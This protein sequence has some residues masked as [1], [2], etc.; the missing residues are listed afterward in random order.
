MTNKEGKYSFSFI[1]FDAHKPPKFTEVKNK[2]WVIFG[3]DKEYF[4]NYPLYLLDNYD[5]SATHNAIINGKI[6][7]IVGNGLKVN[8]FNSA[9][10]LATAKGLIRSVNANEDADDLNR[11]LA[12]DLTTFGG[13]YV[14]LINNRVDGLSEVYHLDFNSIRRSK[15]DDKVW[16]YTSDWE[17]RKPTQ[18]EDF[19]TFYMFEGTFEQGKDYLLEYRGYR[20]G[21]GAYALPDYL[22][23]NSSIEMD[24]R[25]SNYLLNNVKGGFSAG[26]LINFFNGMPTT[27]EKR[28]IEKRIK[29]K[30]SGDDNGGSFVLNFN[31][32]E[33]KSAEIIPIPTNGNDDRFNLLEKQVNNKL[34]VAHSVTSPL[35]F[36]VKTEGQLGGRTEI[37]EAFEIFQ[38]TY[39]NNRQRILEK[40]WND[41][42][43][44]KGVNATL[45]IIE[46]Q[47]ITERLSEQARLSVMT[48]DEIREELGLEPLNVQTTEI[49]NK[50]KDACCS[51]TKFQ[52][53]KDNLMLE[54]FEGCGWDDEELEVVYRR[55]LVAGSIE[56]AK[57]FAEVT[58]FQ[59][60]VL[61][62]LRDNPKLPPQEIAKALEVET[63]QVMDALD[64]LQIEGLIDI[65]EGQVNITDNGIEEAEQEELFTVYKYKLRSDAPTLKAGGESRLFCRIML[66]MSKSKSWTIE[67]IDR[68]NN[69]QGL[70]VFTSR[71]GYYH[72][73]NTGV[74]VPYCRHIWEQRLV[75]KKA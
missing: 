73:P 5:R 21:D 66:G 18:N 43:M 48:Q 17:S 54:H 1:N 75:R 30:F 23:A 16:F 67:D 8:S 63:K 33:S 39:V 68:L 34:F 2:E 62:L 19:K 65:V 14:E 20:A 44:I 29:S 22:A 41:I 32:A 25:I 11:K 60:E 53:D 10:D 47:P 28:D 9:M 42:L 64:N 40:F 74:N 4:N 51:K 37:V 59:N 7:Y 6:N 15:E 45:E 13:F 46:T 12:T 56:D 38:N 61:S 36:G 58:S 55:D 35:L 57:K 49:Q 24:W 26:Y 70:D 50:F 52:E 27:E 71:G 72:N 69:G 3:D 31:H